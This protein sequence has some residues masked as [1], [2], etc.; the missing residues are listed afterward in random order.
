[1]LAIIAQSLKIKC[2]SNK[3]VISVSI[4][5]MKLTAYDIFV[6]ICL[7]VLY[8]A[9]FAEHLNAFLA[10]SVCVAFSTP[11]FNCLSKHTYKLIL[12]SF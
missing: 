9:L 12:L 5:T 1:M 8:F 4:S 3:N 7:Y 2:H 10:L 11:I 6:Y